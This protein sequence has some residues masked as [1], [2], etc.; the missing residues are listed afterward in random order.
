M[1]VLITRPEG[2]NEETAVTLASAGHDVVIAPLMKIVPV[3][4]DAPDP[5]NLQA[6]VLTSGHA[7]SKIDAKLYK[8]LPVFCIGNATATAAREYGFRAKNAGAGDAESLAEALSTILDLEGKAIFYPCASDLAVPLDSLL[9]TKGFKVEQR[10]VYSANPVSEVPA[11]LAKALK[12]KKL[13]AAMFFSPRSAKV[14]ADLVKEAG[15]SEWCKDVIAVVISRRTIPS[16]E[17][18]PFSV[19]ACPP[20]PDLNSMIAALAKASLSH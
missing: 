19:I 9:A 6:L 5:K 4:Y 2:R 1:R 11:N 12:E 10:V 8:D 16:L 3:A 20:R 14:F 18:L 13:D 15:L 17:G 7:A